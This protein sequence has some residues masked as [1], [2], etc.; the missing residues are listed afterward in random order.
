M[1]F[2]ITLLALSLVSYQGVLPGY[3]C[4]TN[5]CCQRIEASDVQDLGNGR[6]RIK[7][8]G[9]EPSYGVFKSHDGDY[10]LCA[11]DPDPNGG[12]TPFGKQYSPRCLAVPF[13]GS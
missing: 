6:Y 7:E 5:N 2:A 3:C 13:Q 11:C 4:W 9:Q 1:I 8:S 12:W 10:H